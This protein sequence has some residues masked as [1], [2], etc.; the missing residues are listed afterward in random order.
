NRGS[1]FYLALYWAEA[2]AHQNKNASLKAEFKTMA[3]TLRKNEEKIIAEL[4][5]I[6]R[7]AVNIG[8]YYKPNEALATKSMR[9]NSLLNSILA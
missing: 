4:N 1:H 6:Q 5:E 8:G 9:P 7:T 3:E 2:L